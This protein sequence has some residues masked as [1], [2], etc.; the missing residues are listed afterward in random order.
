[1]C[2]VLINHFISIQIPN[3]NVN[4]CITVTQ[5]FNTIAIKTPRVKHEQLERNFALPLKKPKHHALKTSMIMTIKTGHIKPI[6]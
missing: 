6:F 1:M 3:P 2:F 5:Q 4:P